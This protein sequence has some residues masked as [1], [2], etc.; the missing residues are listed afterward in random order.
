MLVALNVD[1]FV[2]GAAMAVD[3]TVAHAVAVLAAVA[4]SGTS[5]AMKSLKEADLKSSIDVIHIFNGH[6]KAGSKQHLFSL[7]NSRN[8][9]SPRLVG[10]MCTFNS[11]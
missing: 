1:A 5:Q 9:W 10:M 2:I 4:E 11:G 6:A 3:M 8:T 7:M